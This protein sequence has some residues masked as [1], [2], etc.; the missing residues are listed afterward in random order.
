M[1]QRAEV[2]LISHHRDV[3]E[4][5][6]EQFPGQNAG[7]MNVQAARPR[8]NDRGLELMPTVLLRLRSK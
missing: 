3:E 6:R 1:L 8:E 5:S 2:H 4:R 7:L